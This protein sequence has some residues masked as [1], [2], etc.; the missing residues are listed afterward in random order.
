MQ[1]TVRQIE[2]RRAAARTLQSHQ[3]GFGN[4]QRIDFHLR[5]M[6]DVAPVASLLASWPTIPKRRSTG[7]RELLTNAVEHGL[8]SSGRT[9]QGALSGQWHAGRRTRPA[10]G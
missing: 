9:G 5:K 7:L 3:S 6:S 8:L 2:Q 4:I 10:R 1:A